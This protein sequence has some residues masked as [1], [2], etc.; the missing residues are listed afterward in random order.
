MIIKQCHVIDYQKFSRSE[1]TVGSPPKSWPYST[2]IH[3]LTPSRSSHHAP[4]TVW[5]TILRES[6]TTRLR[7]KILSNEDS[8]IEY[9]RVYIRKLISRNTEDFP[10]LDGIREMTYWKSG[11]N[12]TGIL[13][14]DPAFTRALW[15]RRWRRVLACQDSQKRCGERGQ[16]NWNGSCL[17]IVISTIPTRGAAQALDT[18]HVISPFFRIRLYTLQTAEIASVIHSK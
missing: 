12:R 16:Q 7:V 14:G 11:D 9:P 18:C 13:A 5:T 8:E 17:R 10:E 6:G 1:K 2:R 3:T 4:R 15:S